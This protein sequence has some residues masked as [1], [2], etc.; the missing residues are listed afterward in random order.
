[1]WNDLRYAF[2]ALSR[3]RAFA[4][5]AV[6]SL[7]VGIGANTAIFSVVNGVLLR[8]LPYHDPER[9][10]AIREVVPKL[11]HLYPTLPVNLNHYFEWRKH[12]RAL[13]SVAV[14]RT[15]TFNLT[16]V[17]E[18]ELLNGAL[19]TANIFHVLGVNPRSG[20]AFMDEEDP[21]GHEHVVVIS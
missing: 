14:V 16:G 3:E 1:M 5:M 8:P 18:P 2:R 6:L 9:L 10:V 15:S 20:R 12:C 21:E 7:A 13:E 19:V 17:G 11:A 4:A